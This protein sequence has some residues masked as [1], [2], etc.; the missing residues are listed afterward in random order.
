MYNTVIT[1][2][3]VTIYRLLYVMLLFIV[4]VII[5]IKAKLDYCSFG[6]ISLKIQRAQ[7][8]SNKLS[9]NTMILAEVPL[10]TTL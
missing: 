8:I 9:V 1:L 5:T 3:S 7:C 2:T 4:L 6:V 10:L